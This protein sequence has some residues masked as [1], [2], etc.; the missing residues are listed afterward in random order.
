MGTSC[1]MAARV[2]YLAGQAFRETGLALD[3]LGCNV[4][5]ASVH[6]YQ[7]CRSR[8]LMNLFDMKPAA[9]KTAYIAPTA[10]VIGQVTIEEG[11]SIWPSC[12]VRGDEGAVQVG[13]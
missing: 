9:D 7:F 13:P 5:G 3:R 10:E 4:L 12:V 1:A 6:N 11:A 2:A 8:P